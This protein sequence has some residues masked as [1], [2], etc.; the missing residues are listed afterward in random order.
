MNKQIK[1]VLACLAAVAVLALAFWLAFGGEKPQKTEV[2]QTE[3]IE[4]ISEAPVEEMPKNTGDKEKKV[5]V[6]EKPGEPEPGQA[7]EPEAPTEAEVPGEAEAPAGPETPEEPQATAQPEQPE[8][9]QASVCTL[10]ISCATLLDKL[11]TLPASVCELVPADGWILA[12]VQEEF[13]DG[14]SVLDILLRVTQREGIHMEYAGTAMGNAAYLEGIGNIYEFDAGELSGWMYSVNGTFPNF[15]CGQYFPQ[16]G[17][18]IRLV[19]TCD[20]GADVGDHYQG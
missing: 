7:P 5:E 4:P 3:I 14:E 15:G 1:A 2:E 16:P 12:P 6:P 20:L 17:D 10:S 13:S 19:Y 18:E 9:P 11:D 8:A